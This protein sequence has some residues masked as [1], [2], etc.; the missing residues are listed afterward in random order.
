MTK[1]I[2]YLLFSP[3]LTPAERQTLKLYYQQQRKSFCERHL[4]ADI[5]PE[6]EELDRQLDAEEAMR[7]HEG[8]E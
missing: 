6:L 5:P 2:L 7:R 3:L 8:E 1:W 4:I